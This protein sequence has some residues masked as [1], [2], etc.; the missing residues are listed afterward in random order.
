MNAYRSIDCHR[1]L[2]L[3]LVGDVG[4]LMSAIQF[5][6][7]QIGMLRERLDGPVR[8]T[9]N[10]RRKLLAAAKTLGDHTGDFLLIVTDQTRKRWEKKTTANEATVRTKT[11]TRGR[12]LTS[13][14]IEKLVVR[15]ATD[16]RLNRWSKTRIHGELRKMG[17]GKQVSR[18]TVGNIMTAH[19]FEPEP[20]RGHGTWH[21]FIKSH[22]DTMWASDFFTKTVKTPQGEKAY[23]TLFFKHIGTRRVYI[24]GSTPNPNRHWVSQQARNFCMHLQDLKM[25]ATHLIRDHD[26]CY[27]GGFDDVLKAEGIDVALSA[28]GVPEMNG[29]AESF[30]K[31]IKVEC[32][33]HFT[34]FSD[35]HLAHLLREYVDGHYNT[36]RPHQ[37]LDNRPIGLPEPAEHAATFS[38]DDVVCDHR[39]GG[40]LK[41]YRWKQAACIVDPSTEKS[42]GIMTRENQRI[43]CSPSKLNPSP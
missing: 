12:K 29:Y 6:E 43:P 15:M 17:L 13:E 20:N 8:V 37:G 27:R 23:Y 22:N 36:V 3:V 34:V 30:V 31:T 4:R 25:K 26:S 2:K 5:L 18:S 1:L 10:E 19:G 41:S 24:A 38:Q 16:N 39:C 42:C 28:V 35:E 40:I 33:D 7:L 14:D 11:D 9:P 32:L 21:E